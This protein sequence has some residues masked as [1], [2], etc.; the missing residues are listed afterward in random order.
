MQ[1]DKLTG[2]SK[3]KPDMKN[4]PDEVKSDKWNLLWFARDGKSYIGKPIF[5]TDVEAE[6]H[7]ITLMGRAKT[8]PYIKFNIH[9]V[10]VSKKDISHA[11]PMPVK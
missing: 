6:Q 10:R 9:N 8:I 2:K 1:K 3:R 5:K 4:F 7:Y 11:V